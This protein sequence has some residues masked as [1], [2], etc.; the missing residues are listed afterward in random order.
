MSGNIFRILKKCKYHSNRL[1]LHQEFYDKNKDSLIFVNKFWKNHFFYYIQDPHFYLTPHRQNRQSINILGGILGTSATD[2]NF[3]EDYL[4]S[5]KCKRFLSNNL[6]VL[7][8]DDSIITK[9]PMW[10][11][12]DGDPVEFTYSSRQYL[13]YIFPR[14]IG[15]C[16][17]DRWVHVSQLDW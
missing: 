11:Q 14:Q 1:Q 6:R 10:L 15:I 7:L 8:E 17:P 9:Q 16:F 2:H 5:R 4:N 12:L 13:E 3:F